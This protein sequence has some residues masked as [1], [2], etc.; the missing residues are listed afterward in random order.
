LTEITII[1]LA[2][3]IIA[4]TGCEL[5]RFYVKWLGGPLYGKASREQQ[6]SLSCIILKLLFSTHPTHNFNKLVLNNMQNFQ[7]T[8][9]S[10]AFIMWR[11]KFF[12]NMFSG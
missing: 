5:N 9:N 6:L 4:F 2:P 12:L 1:P 7:A 10:S 3:A 11:G 8:I